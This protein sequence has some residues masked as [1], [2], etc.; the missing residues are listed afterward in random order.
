M[1]VRNW[2]F[3][4]N[5]PDAQLELD[6]VQY[7]VW[8]KEIG[9]NGTP[10]YQGYI[11]MDR[12]CRLSAM[13]KLIPRAH[14]EPRRGTQQQAIDYCTKQE[15]RVE[16]PFSIG[17]PKKQGE[18]TDLKAAA[19]LVLNGCAADVA[20]EMPSVYVKYHQGLKALERAL[21]V[22]K[23]IEWTPRPWQE[24]II[25]LLP[26]LRDDRSILWVLDTIGNVGKSSLSRF[27]VCNHGAVLLDGKRADM[28]YAYAK[29][30]I[31]IF[32][33]PRNISCTD[34]DQYVT[35]A[36]LLKN[37]LLFSTKYDSHMKVFDPPIVIFFSN[38]LPPEGVW[39]SDRAHVYEILSDGSLNKHARANEACLYKTPSRSSL[40]D[41]SS[42]L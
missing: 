4:L 6:G 12:V 32:D 26:S 22:L 17:E 3:T 30:R 33:L 1:A 13:K 2:L 8:Q 20:R 29:Q 9:E 25:K 18:R 15:T 37:G 40:D 28:A 21:D 35:F 41:A 42:D 5:H 36:E 10:H 14:F 34:V 24:A 11:E 39:S 38:Q 7:A 23:P 27:L 31:V 19:E 16:G